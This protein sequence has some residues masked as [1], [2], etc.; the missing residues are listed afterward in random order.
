LNSRGEIVGGY[1][2]TD[3]DR[4]DFLW[5]PLKP[6]APGE[7]G[8]DNG[9]PHMDVDK[10]LSIWRK[11]VPAEKRKN[12]MIVDPADRDRSLFVSDP[13]KMLPRRIRIVPRKIPLESIVQDTSARE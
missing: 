8:N 5:I 3:S 10:V 1:Y 12:W 4:I 2:Y 13:S 9:N 7:T 6:K 11:S